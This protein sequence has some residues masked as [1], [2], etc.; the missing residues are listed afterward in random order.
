[1]WLHEQKLEVGQNKGF[2]VPQLWFSI[3]KPIK[4]CGKSVI[5]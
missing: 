4:K 1:M 5:S 3:Y 2:S